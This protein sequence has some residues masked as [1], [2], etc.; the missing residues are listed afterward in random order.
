[1]ELESTPQSQAAFTLEYGLLNQQITAHLVPERCN[2]SM[3]KSRV[4]LEQIERTKSLIIISTRT[5][6]GIDCESLI[7]YCA[8]HF[9]LP[10]M[11]MRY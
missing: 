3:S 6:F 7:F 2:R 1:M 5:L 8:G 4:V 11:D 9:V 10:F